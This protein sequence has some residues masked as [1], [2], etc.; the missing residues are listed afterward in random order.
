MEVKVTDDGVPPGQATGG[1]CGCRGVRYT[2]DGPLRSVTDCHCEPCRRF[3]GHHLAATQVAVRHI[4][5]DGTETLTWFESGLGV[6]YGFCGR[7]GSSLFWRS[8]ERPDMLSITAGTLDPPS[9]LTTEVAL[10]TAEHGDYHHPEPVA[11]C[12]DGD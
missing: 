7:C 8:S 9:G 10:F 3:T 6:Q 11:V 5:F 12:H 4:V 1:G 2:I